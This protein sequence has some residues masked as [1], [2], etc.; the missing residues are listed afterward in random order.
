M[1]RYL[2]PFIA[3]LLWLSIATPLVAA[4]TQSDTLTLAQKQAF[5]EQRGF[6]ER[7]HCFIPKGTWM[8]GAMAS[9]STTNMSNYNFLIV[10]GIDYS[11]YSFNVSPVVAYSFANNMSAGGRFVY[12]RSLVK[13]DEASLGFGDDLSIGVNN[14]Y[15]LTHT[16]SGMAIWRQFIPL[17]FSK[18]LALFN[19]LQL[20]CGG[21]QSKLAYDSPVKGTYSSSVDV[22]IGLSPGVVAFAA[23]NVAIEVSVGVLGLAYSHTTQVHNQV[24]EGTVGSASLNYKINLF[25]IG[26]G[27]A[28]YL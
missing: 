14:Y 22:S 18:R 4:E 19:E 2:Y 24:E 3:L 23:Q 11:G 21:S 7:Q 8:V 5:R 6:S 28:F 13:I 16:Y 27:V 25:S 15:M 10:N 12:S 1:N 17:G 20:E 26:L 9:Y